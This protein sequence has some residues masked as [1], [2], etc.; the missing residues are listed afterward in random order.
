MAKTYNTI[1]SVSTGD[2]YTATAHNNIVTNVNGYRVP[3]LCR[4][5]RSGSASAAITPST[6]TTGFLDWNTEDVDTETDNMWDAAA[7]TRITVRTAGVYLVQVNYTLDFTGTVTTRQA[8]ILHTTSGGTDTRIAGFY[9]VLSQASVSAETMTA[10]Y[11]ASVGDY[12]R[13]RIELMTG[14]SSITL[15]ND[16]TC[17][18]SAMW[19]G[20]VS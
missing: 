10:V 9:S 16:P 2:V 20:Q 7:G 3:P 5:R 1:P 15:R 12:F 4:V 19:L 13:V 11:S 18:F 8:A 14:A 17:T 6:S